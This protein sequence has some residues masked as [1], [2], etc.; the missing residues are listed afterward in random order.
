MFLQ[1]AA[2]PPP[3][4]MLQFN[5]SETSLMLFIVFSCTRNIS[6]TLLLKK[7]FSLIVK[8]VGGKY[9]RYVF[10]GWIILIFSFFME[11]IPLRDN[12]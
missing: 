2:N 8:I 10:M 3:Y 5:N 12:I 11:A 4:Y 6:M 7:Y 1:N 9:L